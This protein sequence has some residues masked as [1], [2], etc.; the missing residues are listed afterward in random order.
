M[1]QNNP[2]DALLTTLADTDGNI[3]GVTD[4]ALDVHLRQ[5]E[6]VQITD[7]TGNLLNSTGGALN[8]AIQGAVPVTTAQP[9]AVSTTNAAQETGGNLAL[10]TQ[11]LTALQANNDILRQISTTL[12][13]LFL[14]EQSHSTNT[15]GDRDDIMN[16]DLGILN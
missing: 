14:L 6:G 1:I 9:L 12:N 10:H 11:L 8:V 7:S 13:A 15:L 3:V 16:A 2:G 4:N 5:E